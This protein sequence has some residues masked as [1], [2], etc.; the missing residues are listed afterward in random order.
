METKIQAL[1]EPPKI[2]IVM[3]SHA[4]FT[5]MFDTVFSIFSSNDL[6]LGEFLWAKSQSYIYQHFK[7]HNCPFLQVNKRQ[8]VQDA[9][10]EMDMIISFA[11]C[12]SE[13]HKHLYMT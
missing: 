6:K 1:N 7:Q 12:K 2:P 3:Q 4:E 9:H 8:V 13:E 10:H 11:V 5:L